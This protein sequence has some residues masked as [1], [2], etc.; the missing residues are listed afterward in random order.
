MHFFELERKGFSVVLLKDDCLFLCA[1]I[2]LKVAS[3]TFFP[4]CWY[5]TITSLQ[6]IGFWKDTQ[7]LLPV[8]LTVISPPHWSSLRFI[9]NFF[10]WHMVTCSGLWQAVFYAYVGPV[11]TFRGLWCITPTSL[12][13]SAINS[14]ALWPA[15][16]PILA[17]SYLC[18]K[19]I[20]LCVWSFSSEWCPAS[21]KQKKKKIVSFGSLH[22][23]S[24]DLSISTLGLLA[25]C[26]SRFPLWEGHWAFLA[27]SEQ[28]TF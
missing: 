7:P 12:T 9:G 24:T 1:F 19:Q 17:N 10:L 22:V 6:C 11:V 27:C 4:N 26:D 3:L 16:W 18:F 23:H 2:I 28:Q 14:Q 5:I 15:E 20:Y 8:S 25:S 13:A 21:I